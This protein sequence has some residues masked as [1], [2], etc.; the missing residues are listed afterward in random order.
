[1]KNGKAPFK[2]KTQKN[3]DQKNMYCTTIIQYIMWRGIWIGLFNY[4]YTRTRV[5]RKKM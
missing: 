3:G 2:G 4:S 5:Y 1:M